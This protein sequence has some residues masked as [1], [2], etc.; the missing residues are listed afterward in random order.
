MRFNQ[1]DTVVCGLDNNVSCISFIM[2]CSNKNE[3][4]TPAFAPAFVAASLVV[5][6]TSIIILMSIVII[7][8]AIRYICYHYYS[9][10]IFS[11]CLQ[12]H[13]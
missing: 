10:S 12:F 2:D 6:T 1:E 4:M 9:I 3:D 7:Y 13:R 11:V 5:N 8:T